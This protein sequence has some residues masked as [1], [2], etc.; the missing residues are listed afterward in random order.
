M[1]EFSFPAKTDRLLAHG[2]SGFADDPQEWVSMSILRKQAL[3]NV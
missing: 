3:A 2:L 1:M